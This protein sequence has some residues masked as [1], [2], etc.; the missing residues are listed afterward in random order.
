MRY[1]IRFLREKRVAA[2]LY[3][4]T[5]FLFLAV[6]GL[7]HIENLPKL[8]YGAILA[9]IFWG[10]AGIWKGTAYVRRCR[11]LEDTVRHYEQSG[12]LLTEGLREEGSTLWEELLELLEA[13]N[14]AGG[15][16]R[17]EWEAKA[18]DCNDYYLMWTHQI[19]TPIAAMKLLLENGGE[20]DK[21]SFFLREELWKI[22]QY[23][24]MVLAFQR[25]ESLSSDLVLKEY[26]LYDIL[27][28]TA[29][30]FSI[31][32]INKGLSL[33]LQEMHMKVLTDEKWLGF[34]IRQLISNSVKYT[35]QGRVTIRTSEE[36]ERVV[37]CVE[38]TG[39]GIRPEDLPRIFERGFTGYNG[40]MDERSTG[41]GLYLCRRVFRHLGIEVQAESEVGTGT[42]MTL[43]IPVR[44]RRSQD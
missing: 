10:A 34:C 38:D 2:A 9:L 6:G 1:W 42:R 17:G 19:K 20:G 40:R 21:N 36:E 13:V 12:E 26:D 14:A 7:Y 29:R 16:Q 41:I 5:V 23:V 43:Y 3:L 18:A 39:I 31:L 28:R 32:F 11:K 4:I 15:A 30:D 44:D 33:E 35:K 24:E 8:L 27:K 37:L 25:L 22:E